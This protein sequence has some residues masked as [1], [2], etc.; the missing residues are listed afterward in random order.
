MEFKERL[1]KIR[2]EKGLSQ[3]KLADIVGVHVTNISRY[4]RGENKPTT[5]VLV[6]LANALSVSA[7]FLMNGT[8]NENAS[9]AI[10]D[11][12]LLEQF[13]KVE[14]LPKDKKLLVK[15]FLD[16]FIMKSE[17]QRKFI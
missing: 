17:L 12:E 7:D 10:S 9:Q 3:S 16:A 8:I 15:E 5:E 13:K 6:N 2:T 4:E 14:Q 11:K 1:K